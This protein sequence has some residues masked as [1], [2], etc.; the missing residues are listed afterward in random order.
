MT[1]T[2]SLAQD[3]CELLPAPLDGWLIPPHTLPRRS[4][5]RGRDRGGNAM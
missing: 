4:R 3:R 5:G 2:E 1:N